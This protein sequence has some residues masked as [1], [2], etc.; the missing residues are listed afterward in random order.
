MTP[1][2]MTEKLRAAGV[3]RRAQVTSLRVEAIGGGKGF[4]GE[5]GRIFLDYDVPENGAPATVI[6]K[7]PNLLPEIRTNLLHVYVREYFFYLE[8]AADTPLRLP[9][10]YFGDVDIESEKAMLLFEDLA[11]FREIGVRSV[12]EET[13]RLVLDQLA[14][15]HAAWWDDSRLNSF[16][17]LPS[18]DRGLQEIL[19][20]FPQYWKSFQKRMA[21]HLTPSLVKIGNKAHSN[22]SQVRTQLARRPQTLL[23]GDFQ[24]GNLLLKD[25]NGKTELGVI[26]WQVC[27]RGRCMRDVAHFI[28][29]TL[30]VDVRRATEED[31][32][33]YYHRRL[34]SY[35]IRD[36]SYEQACADYK[37]SLLDIF[38]FM[39]WISLFLDFSNSPDLMNLVVERVCR[40]VE[41]HHGA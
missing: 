6:L 5:I 23:H 19:H 21:A 35:G 17:W 2:W 33:S 27:R 38:N 10:L 26:D 22:L 3:I 12:D 25:V 16:D 11:P 37:L 15:L 28:A 40:I 29:L 14:K 24:G 31:L 39:V 18:I 13:A 30:D 34:V 8:A 9:R 36:F 1:G 32:L 4:T 7:S 41:D 20:V